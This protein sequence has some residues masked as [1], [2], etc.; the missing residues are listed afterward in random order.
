[1]EILLS[2]I[3]LLELHLHSH[4]PVHTHTHVVF[5]MDLMGTSISNPSAPCMIAAGTSCMTFCSVFHPHLMKS[6][7][8]PSGSPEVTR[9]SLARSSQTSRERHWPAE[10][11]P[12]FPGGLD[13]VQLLR[14]VSLPLHA[15]GCGVG[16]SRGPEGT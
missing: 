4:K 15:L 8:L 9:G 14:L 3:F 11:F 16:I 12:S 2:N 7:H 1:M 5:N 13:I 10:A 6:I